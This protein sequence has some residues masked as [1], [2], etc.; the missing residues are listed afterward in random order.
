M[1]LV[2]QPRLEKT[3]HKTDKLPCIGLTPETQVLNVMKQSSGR[4]KT[5]V[6]FL[7]L[8]SNQVIKHHL[9]GQY[10]ETH[11]KRPPDEIIQIDSPSDSETDLETIKGDTYEIVGGVLK[12]GGQKEL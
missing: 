8:L 11:N 6:N 12:T 9:S 10:I 3:P 4:G 1:D 5:R 2:D 7:H